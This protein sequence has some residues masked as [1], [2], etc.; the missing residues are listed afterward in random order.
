MKQVKYRSFNA[1][2]FHYCLNGF[3]HYKPL[4]FHAKPRVKIETET[5]KNKGVLMK[6]TII[7]MMLLGSIS[8]CD[9][10]AKTVKVTC[11][12]ESAKESLRFLTPEND[13][14]YIEL[15]YVT[16]N[17]CLG[18]VCLDKLGRTYLLQ[19]YPRI[20]SKHESK[21][22]KRTED[23]SFEITL[24]KIRVIERMNLGDDFRASYHFT[25]DKNL[26]DDVPASELKRSLNCI[27][28]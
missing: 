10:H 7:G 8:I 24:P 17:L 19:Q 20:H 3:T 1:F 28:Q 6:K 23:R 14:M 2:P 22:Y 26:Y 12:G 13:Q 5:L 9:V 16:E 25:Y 27:V 11:L 21:F 18:Q 4:N 15:E